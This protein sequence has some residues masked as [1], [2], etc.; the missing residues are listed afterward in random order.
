[1]VIDGR[2]KS[3][4]ESLVDALLPL[5]DWVAKKAFKPTQP[6]PWRGN[7]PLPL[8]AKNLGV[9]DSLNALIAE[10]DDAD[11]L[12]RYTAQATAPL[13]RS[14]LLDVVSWRAARGLDS[15]PVFVIVRSENIYRDPVTREAIAR[16]TF[17]EVNLKLFA[18]AVA[19]VAPTTPAQWAAF[20][21]TLRNDTSPAWTDAAHKSSVFARQLL[22]DVL[23]VLLNMRT[24]QP[25]PW[26]EALPLELGEGRR[27]GNKFEPKDAADAT[28]IFEN[29]LAEVMGGKVVATNVPPPPAGSPPATTKPKHLSE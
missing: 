15:Q 21:D 29:V 24:A 18:S 1:M 14:P 13:A 3:D 25:S 16:T 27:P 20:A 12:A 5:Q 6:V 4:I 17:Y 10:S 9:V 23:T 19:A 7:N 11:L 2:L 8:N 26:R 22:K 28:T